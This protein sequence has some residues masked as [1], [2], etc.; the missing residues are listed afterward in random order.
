MATGLVLEGGG[1]RA[2]F[3]AAVLDVFIDE[4]LTFDGVI[5]VSAGATQGAS[6]ISKQK[7]R[8]LKLYLTY[9]HDPRFMSLGN[10]LKHGDFVDADFAY[11]RIPEE[12]LPYDFAAAAASSMAFYVVCTNLATATPEYFRINDMLADID[13]V[14]ASASLPYLSKTI[15]YEGKE[16]LDGG[17]VESIPIYGAL[18]QGF[19]KNVVVLTRHKE[20]RKSP[21]NYYL[22][23]L[24]YP[25][26]KAFIKALH[27]RHNMYNSTVAF[28]EKEAEAGRVFL[29]RP[30]VPL[31]ISRLESD[32][33]K[34]Q[35]IYDLGLREGRACLPA[36]RQWLAEGKSEGENK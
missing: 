26:R 32:P 20:F 22:P 25:R 13:L 23:Y 6:Y 10:W 31:N 34:I 5:G 33:K 36:L 28:L 29:I 2:V 24:F 11:H 3:Q 14:R 16:L 9:A 12:L 27:E 7:G 8:S 21:E 4:G 19:D 18:A 35:E 30:S 1:V 15:E 17:V